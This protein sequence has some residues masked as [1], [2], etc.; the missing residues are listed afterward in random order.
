MSTQTEGILSPGLTVD[1]PYCLNTRGIQ[2]KRCWKGSRLISKGPHVSAVMVST[3]AIVLATVRLQSIGVTAIE[4]I[5]RAT[6]GFN[7]EMVGGV[8]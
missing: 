6:A 1:R 8:T 5:G 3:Y 7:Y 4:R 2:M